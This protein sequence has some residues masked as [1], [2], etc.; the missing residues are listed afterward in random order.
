MIIVSAAGLAA[1][2]PCLYAWG[3][4]RGAFGVLQ[5]YKP[6]GTQR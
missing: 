6:A 4:R 3:T 1:V 5:L 2:P